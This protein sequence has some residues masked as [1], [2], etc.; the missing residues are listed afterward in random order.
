MVQ[1]ALITGASQGLGLALASELLR[2]GAN[3]ILNAR[4]P[5]KLSAALETLQADKTGEAGQILD[6]VVADVSVPAEASRLLLQAEKALGGRC[7][8]LVFCC[9][10]SS[11]P[12]FFIDHAPE[13][14]EAE[15]RSN[16]FTALN[17]AHVSPFPRH[18]LNQRNEHSTPCIL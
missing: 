3:V 11:T 6:Y 2:H 9:A 13:T 15:M 16:Y 5:S 8:D 12:A 4:T 17:V 14:F 18:D 10:G 1:S 7:P